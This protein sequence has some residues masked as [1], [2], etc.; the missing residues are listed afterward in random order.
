M[1]Q[2]V[3]VKCPNCNSTLKIKNVDNSAERIINCPKCM[4]PIKVAFS[5][6]IPETPI[7]SET[8]PPSPYSSP[9]PPPPAPL[10]PKKNNNTWLIVIMSILIAALAGVLIWLL[11][12]KDKEPSRI[13]HSSDDEIEEYSTAASAQA[14]VS[15]QA[16][17]SAEFP[18]EASASQYIE[19]SASA[20]AEPYYRGEASVGSYE[21]SYSLPYIGNSYYNIGEKLYNRLSSSGFVNVYSGMTGKD[22]ESIRYMDQS[23]SSNQLKVENSDGYRYQFFF[24]GSNKHNG[25][26]TGVAVSHACS[27]PENECYNF[28]NYIAGSGNFTWVKDGLYRSSS[29]HYVSPGYSNGRF[30]IYYY[31]PNAPAKDPAPRK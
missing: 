27:S 11:V 28:E 23:K 15:A 4:T 20:K 5:A 31:L 6:A 17:A 29:G 22:F 16:S 26:L 24:M 18:P 13:H 2:E 21:S 3:Q 25:R 10:A 30:Y 8:M 1:E 12:F 9:L 14:S 19:A 7:P